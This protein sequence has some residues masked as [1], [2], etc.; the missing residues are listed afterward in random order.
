MKAVVLGAREGSGNIGDETAQHLRFSLDM[1]VFAHDCQ[2]SL[3]HYG[4]HPEVLE[5]LDDAEALVIT[6]GRTSMEPFDRIPPSELEDVIYGCLTL[7]LL[8]VR[9][10]VERREGKGGRIVLVGSYAHRH[11]FTTG[12]AYCAAKAGLD[13]AVK[14]LGWEMTDKDFQTFAVHPYHVFGTPMWKKVHDGL[15]EHRN[16]TADEASEYAEKDLKMRV[17]K[18]HEIGEMIGLLLTEP[19]A[20]WLSGT[21]I[22]LFGGTR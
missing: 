7:P 18:P 14:T 9:E 1:Q 3:G 13:M 2:L 19:T 17:M 21:N 16:M 11:P 12:T 20:Q 22:E 5:Q 4:I 15:M 6:L 8:Y 10:Y